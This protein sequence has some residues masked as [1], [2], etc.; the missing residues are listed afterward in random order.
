MITKRVSRSQVLA[1]RKDAIG[2]ERRKGDASYISKARSI[3]RQS[4]AETKQSADNSSLKISLRQINVQY[5][6][7][8]MILLTVMILY[9]ASMNVAGGLCL[10]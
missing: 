9:R 1:K 6:F 3:V 8:Q 7:E 5:T 2:F 10:R 4:A